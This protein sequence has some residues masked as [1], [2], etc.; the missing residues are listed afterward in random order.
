MENKISKPYYYGFADL[1]AEREAK[2]WSLKPLPYLLTALALTLAL[3][4]IFLCITAGT[5]SAAEINLDTI[6]HIESGHNPNAYNRHSG[7]RGLYQVTAP[8][9]ADY[10]KSHGTKFSAADL[11]NPSICRRVASWYIEVEVPRLLRYYH[12]PVNTNTIIRAYNCGIR[13]VIKGYTPK[14]T[15]NYLKK[16]AKLSNYPS[17]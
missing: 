3:G 13:S 16:Y 17:S 5:A 1:D 12:Q 7:A 2:R 9:L 11:F 4:L 15:A 6:E 14:E 8:V 10:N